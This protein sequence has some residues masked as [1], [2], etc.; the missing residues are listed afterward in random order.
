MNERRWRYVIPSVQTST[1][2]RVI[3]TSKLAGIPKTSA[4][5]ESV[6]VVDKDLRDQGDGDGGTRHVGYPG[7]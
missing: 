2:R 6:G 3:P 7:V 4:E 1:D 5:A